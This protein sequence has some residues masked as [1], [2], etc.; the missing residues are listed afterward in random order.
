MKR[1]LTAAAITLGLLTG[2]AAHAAP[3]CHQKVTV[4]GL[5]YLKDTAPVSTK[6]S[7]KVREQALDLISSSADDYNA[8]AVAYV[9]AVAVATADVLKT[10]VSDDIKDLAVQT[11]D[12]MVT[13]F[14]LTDKS[15]KDPHVA[16]GVKNG[17]ISIATNTIIT[18]FFACK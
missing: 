7:K 8:K 5:D 15:Q 3:T 9:A 10:T 14:G 18:A 2:T 17:A 11:A 13:S 4:A 6:V 12:T 16:D 1:I